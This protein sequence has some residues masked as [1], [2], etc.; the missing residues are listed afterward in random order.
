MIDKKI[1]ICFVLSHLPQGGAERQTINL[2]KGLKASDYEITLLLYANTE[3]FYREVFELPIKII[4]NQTQKANKVI[5]NLKNAFFLRKVLKDSDF[6]ILHT[7]LYHNGFWVRI[8]APRKYKDRIIYSIRNTVDA[9]PWSSRLAEKILVK[10]SIVVTNSQK[11]LEQYIDIVGERHRFRVSNIYN[12]IETARFLCDEPPGISGKTIIGTV[13]RQTAL[14]NQIQILQAVN[15]ISK[16]KPVHFFLIGDKT[17]GRSVDNERFVRDHQL[18][19]IVTLLDSQHDIETYYRKF[20]IF[21]LSSLNESCPNVLFEAMLSKCLC[22]VSEGANADK[23]I[24]DGLN[25]LV[26]DGSLP[27][28][29]SKLNVALELISGNKHHPMVNAGFDYAFQNF[30]TDSMMMKYNRLY[31]SIVHK[32]DI[33]G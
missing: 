31:N 14:K 4:V 19:E 16:T 23:F 5:R 28:L 30:S 24:S 9:I 7:L 12:G 6:D 13:G 3:I 2:I 20:N 26:Y 21:V 18:S 29:V 10:K 15:I 17:Q 8:L 1:K 33:D 25:G 22:I 32:T 27:M 11:V